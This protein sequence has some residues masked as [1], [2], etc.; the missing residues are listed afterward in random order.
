[1]ATAR[2]TAVFW[3]KNVAPIYCAGPP[4]VPWV[5]GLRDSTVRIVIGPIARLWPKVRRT[6]VTDAVHVG[7]LTLRSI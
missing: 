4:T 6:A 3:V 7:W 2:I 1:M 5:A